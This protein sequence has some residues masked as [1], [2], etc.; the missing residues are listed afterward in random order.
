VSNRERDD[1]HGP[2]AGVTG[3]GNA[4]AVAL[5][6]LAAGGESDASSVIFGSALQ[7][8]KNPK[9]S[10]GVALIKTDTIILNGNTAYFFAGR[11]C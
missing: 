4:T 2:L 8:F 7:S 11:H 5:G 9:D 6:D 3:S 10:L 1:E